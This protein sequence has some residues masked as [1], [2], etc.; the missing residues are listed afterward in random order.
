MI[1]IGIARP[2]CGAS[3]SCWVNGLFFQFRCGRMRSS[4]ISTK[5][6]VDTGA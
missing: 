6:P 1:Q 4:M 3:L 2:P 5:E